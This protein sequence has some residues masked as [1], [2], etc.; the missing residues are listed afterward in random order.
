[1]P[2]FFHGGLRILIPHPFIQGFIS[3]MYTITIIP[4]ILQT[5]KVKEISKNEFTIKLVA[6]NSV[7]FHIYLKYN[8]NL[9]HFSLLI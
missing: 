7:A 6:C 5:E 4:I 2:N 8:G 3:V 9:G 1:M